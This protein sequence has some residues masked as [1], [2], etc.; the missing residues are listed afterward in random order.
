MLLPASHQA[1]P[2]IPPGQD[3]AID[4]RNLTKRYGS[5]RGITNVNL[6]IAP[7][8]L[9]G[10][11]GPNGAGKTTTIRCLLGL[12][13]A[14]SGSARVLGHDCWTQ[15]DKVRTQ[16]GS[17]PG[18]LRLW[19]WL[20]GMRALKLFGLIRGKPLLAKGK[21]LADELE[22]DLSLPV[23][24]MSRGNRQKLGIILA[25]AHT[26]RVLVLDEPTT[27]LDPLMQDRLR[28]MLRRAA[29][30]GA[31]V[32]FSSHTL[33]EVEALCERVAIVKQ[34]AIVADSTLTLLR[35]DAG[36]DLDV[37]WLE[38]L[39]PKPPAWLP[40][41]AT[42]RP[43]STEPQGSRWIARFRPTKDHTLADILALLHHH[44]DA[45]ADIKLAQP[46]LETLFRRF[47]ESDADDPR[48]VMHVTNEP[49]SSTGD[50][51]SPA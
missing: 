24:K 2:A 42:R 44:K 27:A 33:A 34:G 6:A 19:P 12:L 35:A 29:D 20:T 37:L 10:F 45:I 40:L 43:A 47:Y 41:L 9:Y 1:H 48:P 16:V 21:E 5:R 13:R 50:Q 25:L 3:L 18:D 14:S 23:R 7:G 51:P 39:A 26:P 49:Q 28:S 15:G 8:S 11:L 46:D 22:L 38:N 17:I 31:A 36:Y 4:V 30:D 32:F